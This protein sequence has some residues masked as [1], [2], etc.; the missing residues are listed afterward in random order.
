MGGKYKRAPPL[1]LGTRGVSSVSLKMKSFVAV[2]LATAFSITTAQLKWRL[3]DDGNN[4]GPGPRQ[5]G[6]MAY[7]YSTNSLVVFGG[8]S[9][10]S[11]L[12]NDVW[13]YDVSGNSWSQV[14]SGG[15]DTT[16]PTGRL[17]FNFGI[18]TFEG[19]VML[20]ITHG[21]GSGMAEYDDVWAFRLDTNEWNEINID[22]PDAAPGE[23]YGGHFGALYGDTDT[24]WVGAGFTLTTTLAT[25]YI[26]T[27]KLRFT[28][29]SSARW[30]ELYGQPSRGN[31]FDPL[32][33]HGR[34]LQGSAVVEEEKMVMWGGCMRYVVEV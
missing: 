15:N 9:N 29:R 19:T 5:G 25:R 32:H 21:I 1:I 2:L 4:D 14:H 16:V 10:E 34:C 20:A 6:A 23:R 12:P 28:S 33:P 8:M 7:D 13:T 30:E 27:Y 24:L 22:N 3:L 18:V 31:Q 17:Y 11:T 26:D